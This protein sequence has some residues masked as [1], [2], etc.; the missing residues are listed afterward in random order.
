MEF[1]IPPTVKETSLDTLRMPPPLRAEGNLN[2]LQ[3]IT[4]LRNLWEEGHP[5]IPMRPTQSNKYARYPVIVYGLNM[6]KTQSAEP[7]K[8]YRD[9]EMRLDEDTHLRVEA[10]RFDNVITFTV[11]TE[12]N[13][14]LC[15]TIIEAF[16]DFMYEQTK[17]FKRLGISDIFYSRRLPDREK[18]SSDDDTEERS[19]A[20]LVILEKVYITEEEKINKIIVRARLLL[21]NQWAGVEFWCF[22]PEDEEGTS[23]DLLIYQ[24]PFKVGDLVRIKHPDEQQDPLALMGLSFQIPHMLPE[25]LAIDYM[26]QVSEVVSENRLR[27]VKVDGKPVYIQ[28]SGMG[29]LFGAHDLS[30]YVRAEYID[31]FQGATPLYV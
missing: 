17:V 3:F 26:Y 6:R 31:E 4:L 19:V 11:I 10:Q 21:K 16:E 23:Q 13:P 5:D 18:T 24:H 30:S 15:E 8:R 27:L 25:G 20:Y 2:Y 12:N 29:R 28:N 14:E 22:D 7:K 1:G 9:T